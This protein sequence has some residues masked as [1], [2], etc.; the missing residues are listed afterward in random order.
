M[1]ND[2]R[3]SSLRDALLAHYAEI[4]AR[5]ARSL[6]SRDLAEEVLQEAYLRVHDGDTVAVDKPDAY[7]FRTALNIATD[8]RREESRRRASHSEILAAIADDT[9]DHAK[10]MEDRLQVQALKRA[11]DELTPRR[12]AIVIAARLDGIPHHEIARRLG[13][14]R[15]MVQKELRAAIR[16]CLDR[17]GEKSD[18]DG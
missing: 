14:S 11:L 1:S 4:R 17:L 8:K 3:T 5:L 13:L 18:D 9:R 15:T 12:R 16:H 10:E 2:G 7:I 6:G